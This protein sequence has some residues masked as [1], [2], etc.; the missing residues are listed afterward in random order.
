MEA[1][2]GPRRLGGER[3]LDTYDA[4]RRPVAEATSARAAVR[5]A[6]HSHPGFTPPP[7]A[8]GGRQQGILNVALGYRYPRGAVVGADPAAAVVPENLDLTGAP[9]T[10]APHLWV[11]RGG[12]RISTLDLYERTPVL[13]SD[14]GDPSGWH[15]AA[16]RLADEMSVPLRSYRVGP[17]PEAELVPEG[18]VDWA[19]RHGTTRGGAVLVRPDGFVAW[20]SSGPDPD[21]GS[22]LRRALEGGLS[23][24]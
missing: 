13:L 24:G 9:G 14:A 23:L 2:R 8:G 6:E 12:E 15:E 10:R 4:E 3:L 21:A 22:A 19:E 5:S 17:G 16:T 1:R 20:R 18:E 7:G 11:K